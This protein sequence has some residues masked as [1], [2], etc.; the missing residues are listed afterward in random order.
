MKP[1]VQGHIDVRPPAKDGLEPKRLSI[2][3]STWPMVQAIVPSLMSLRKCAVNCRPSIE[4]EWN[5][6]IRSI[7][8]RMLK[9]EADRESFQILVEEYKTT[10]E[11]QAAHYHELLSQ[12][13]DAFIKAADCTHDDIEESVQALR[14]DFNQHTD[15]E[16]Q[17]RRNA[18]SEQ[19]KTQR[20]LLALIIT[21]AISLGSYALV[22]IDDLQH[23][24]SSG[25]HT[26]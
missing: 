22:V 5:E 9:M 11:T 26:H 21:A 23:Q 7:E 13:L 14:H 10:S 8:E 1:L 18:E 25:N 12:K 3:S 24:V 4:M 16:Q 2:G 6:R 19:K 17:D 15:D 20:M